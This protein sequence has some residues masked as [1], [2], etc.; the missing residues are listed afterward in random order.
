MS[1]WR[2]HFRLPGTLRG[3]HRVVNSSIFFLRKK[4]LGGAGASQ[5]VADPQLLILLTDCKC[6]RYRLLARLHCEWAWPDEKDE[7]LYAH[8]EPNPHMSLA[9]R[10]LTSLREI[11]WCDPE[12][13]EGDDAKQRPELGAPIWFRSPGWVQRLSYF[14]R[15]SRQ[16]RRSFFG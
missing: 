2:F 14:Q 1:R 3:S 16:I 6:G 4:V 9:W 11:P 13:P 10:V 8:Q 15:A 7:Q 12:L 5:S